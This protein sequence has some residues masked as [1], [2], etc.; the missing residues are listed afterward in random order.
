MVRPRMDWLE[1]DITYVC[2]LNCHNCNRMTGIAPGRPEQ[3]ITVAQ[4]DKLIED[5]IRL[6]YPWKEWFLVGGEPTTHPDLDAIVARIAEYRA[7]HNPE[8]RLTLATHGY[9][10]HTQKRLAELAAVFPFL[11]FLNSHKTG[12]I[13]PEFVAPCVA[14]V[15]LDPEWAA[16]HRYEGCSVSSHCGI[17]MN[18]SGFYPCAVA[19]AID[20]LFGLDEAITNLG[21]V[22]E[23]VMIEKYQ[24]FCRLCGYY[25]PICENSQT[26]LSPTWRQ[27][28]SHN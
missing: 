4:I 22:S 27:L 5:S 13:Q 12:P 20:R 25:R 16:N 7:A 26:L 14:P 28:T 10:E 9:G 23:S 21:D 6:Q 2:G 8:L 11:Q 19:G 17:S 3:N 1:L 18:Y 24:V 15:D